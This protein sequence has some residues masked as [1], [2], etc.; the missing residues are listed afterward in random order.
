MQRALSALCS[1]V[2]FC[3]L[4]TIIW[5]HEPVFSFMKK[6]E[7]KSWVIGGGGGAKDYFSYFFSSPGYIKVFLTRKFMEKLLKPISFPH[8]FTR[9]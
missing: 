5:G 3:T 6:E 7:R 9:S 8:I 4:C 2:F 1:G